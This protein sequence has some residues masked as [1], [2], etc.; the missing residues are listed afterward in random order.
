MPTSRYSTQSIDQ[1]DIDAVIAALRS[2]TLTGGEVLEGFE[3]DLCAYT[4]AKAAVALS[5]ATAALHAA[6]AVC[7][8][9]AGSEVIVPAISFAATA[10]AALYCDLIPR[11]ADISYPTGCLDVEKLE[12]LITPQTRAILPVHFAGNLCD[13]TAINDLA[14]RHDLIVI[15]DAA[16]AL[17]TH[18]HNR[19]AG[20]FGQMGIYSF[21]PLKP[22]T[23]AEGG[24]VVT[25]DW[26]LAEKLRRFRS[27]GIERGRLWS[28]EMV[29]LGYNYRLSELH[30]ALGRSQ[31]KRIETFITR[32]R[33]IAQIYDEAF[34]G[35]DTLFTLRFAPHLRSS[36]HLYP[37][38]LAPEL[39]CAK[40]A[41]FEALTQAGI[42]AQ[43][44]YKPIYRHRYYQE[45]F[46]SLPECPS[47][48][49]FYRAELSLPCHQQ[50]QKA[51]AQRVATVLTELTRSETLSRC[52]S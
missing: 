19:H 49:S 28:Q 20:T 11:F 29:T 52:K 36:Y 46:G 6:L 34:A 21:H 33:A 14:D 37:I 16:H 17:G 1:S 10:N 18:R 13:M 47:A 48:E 32:R 50:M 12:A 45:R 8:L 4:G 30:A 42:G 2:D 26:Q 24:A 5:S 35:N 44:H 40:E 22:I 39:W 38:L 51:D 25:D 27:H 41:L 15:E 3:A 43:V 7:D 23:S 9:S 31:L